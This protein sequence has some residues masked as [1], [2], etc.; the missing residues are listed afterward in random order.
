MITAEF[1]ALLGLALTLGVGAI[2]LLAYGIYS[3]LTE[4]EMDFC[5]AMIVTFL[6]LSV[7]SGVMFNE[8]YKEYMNAIPHNQIKILRQKISDA[9]KEYQKYLIDHPEL[10]ELSDIKEIK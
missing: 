1:V 6:C 9:E 8:S 3:A 10:K 4:H 7:L 2:C 5:V